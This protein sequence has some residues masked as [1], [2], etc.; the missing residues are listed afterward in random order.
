[1]LSIFNEF[2]QTSNRFDERTLERV[3]RYGPFQNGKRRDVLAR[4]ANFKDKLT[5]V[6]MKERIKE[7]YGILL[8]DDL[9]FEIQRNNKIL[10]PVYKALRHAKD[11]SKGDRPVRSVKLK[12]GCIVLNGKSYGSENL[13]DL[14]PA[15][16]TD[17]LFTVT[18]KDTTAFFRCYSPLFNQYSCNF[19]VN[20]E[21]F[22]S[23]EKYL[24]TQKAK[25]F[26]DVQTLDQMRKVDDPVTLKHLGKSVKNFSAPT[27]NKEI[28]N[29]LTTGLYCKFS[30]NSNLCDVLKATGNTTL[31]EVNPN[32]RKFGVGLP[33]F[34]KDI[35]DRSKWHGENKLGIALMQMRDAVK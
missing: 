30:Q 26:G 32:D 3:H 10:H 16:A 13:K 27:W 24:M 28:D 1:M 7:K 23:M 35:W 33:L 2:L 31:A 12:D 19:E 21:I 6:E 22:T 4:F 9:P 11:N 5:A 14:P 15:L 17:K 29:I 20:G 25:L 8:L 34:S 18:N